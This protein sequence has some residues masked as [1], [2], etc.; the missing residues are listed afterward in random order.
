MTIA[1][2]AHGKRVE[3]EVSEV[4]LQTDLA[5]KSLKDLI[6][7]RHEDFKSMS[8]FCDFPH[9]RPAAESFPTES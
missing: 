8:K 3:R 7:E 4:R 1:W 5:L 6:I 9:S 2:E